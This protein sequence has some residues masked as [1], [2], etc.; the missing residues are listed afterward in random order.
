MAISEWLDEKEAKNIDVSQITLPEDLSY[1]EVPDE[2]IYY[3]EINPCGFF[4]TENH[5]FSTVERYG[6]WYYCR[7]RDKEASIHTSGT[8]WR[9]FTKD[10]D[11]AVKTAKSHIE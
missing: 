2:T 6:H 1:D 4:C 5:P 9:F 8:E 7:G 10:R 3:K 11:L